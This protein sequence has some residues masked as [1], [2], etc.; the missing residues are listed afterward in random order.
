MS[1]LGDKLNQYIEESGY[2]VNKL[3]TLSGVNR[4]SI[5]RMI[6]ANRLPEQHNIEKL[7]PYLKLTNDQKEGLWKT[8]EITS[9][10]ESLY[11]RRQYML[12]MMRGVYSPG[13]S[14]KVI[15]PNKPDLDIPYPD[16]GKL[17]DYSILHGRYEVAHRLVLTIL[18][19][20]DNDVCVFAPF[21]ND[22]IS[23]FFKHFT[24]KNSNSLHIRHM[25]HFI[26]NP[27][28]ENHINYN[29]SILA[30]ILPLSF[31]SNIDY[32]VYFTYVTAPLTPQSQIMYPYYLII[33]NCLILISLDFDS[34]IFIYSQEMIDEYRKN[35]N[36]IISEAERLVH[37]TSN[38]KRLSEYFPPT[39]IK[40]SGFCKFGSQPW[41]FSLFELDDVIDNLH[42]SDDLRRLIIETAKMHA[43]SGKKIDSH[44]SFFS[45]NGLRLFATDGIIMNFPK[46]VIPHFN[47]NMR[48]KALQ[49]LKEDCCRHGYIIRAINEQAFPLNPHLSIQVT[50]ENRLAISLID[51]EKEEFRVFYMNEPTL[52]DAFV[53]FLEY[54]ATSPFLCSDLAYS[55]D[56]TL[57]IID[58]CI[59][60]VKKPSK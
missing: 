43:D 15:Q 16:T 59:E 54:C 10:G 29:L 49:K 46:D 30:H 25:T 60:L 34:A 55:E 27:C 5:V 17:K 50:Q 58:E 40:R 6:N 56:R 45:E 44:I 1:I 9:S 32:D 14:E 52:M 31:T 35:F 37:S 22:F 41:L 11:E 38:I 33:G 42:I 39:N 18:T 4:T 36:S 19:Q 2:S 53:D 47:K 28:K 7:L 13:F 3:A 51:H 20:P 8:Y 12:K 57:E 21:T 26:K 23:D 48:I 24:L